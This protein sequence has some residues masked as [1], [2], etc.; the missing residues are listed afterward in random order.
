MEPKELLEKDNLEDYRVS[1]LIEVF[2]VNELGE[3]LNE[4]SLFFF[5]EDVA[6]GFIELQPNAKSY[7]VCKALVLYNQKATRLDE[8]DVIG[9]LI[10]APCTIVAE[11]AIREE[12]R[13]NALK[14]LTSSE[15]K[16]LNIQE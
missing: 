13:Q 1:E 6:Q 11:Q 9:F 2:K 16:L 14:K 3:R 7:R 15:I 10:G 4:P 12:I 5:D 8:D